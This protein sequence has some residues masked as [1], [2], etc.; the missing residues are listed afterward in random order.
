MTLIIHDTTTRIFPPGP[1]NLWNGLCYWQ[2][3]FCLIIG[4]HAK[5]M[6]C[7]TLCRVSSIIG[8]AERPLQQ[9]V[10]LWAARRP[11]APWTSDLLSQSQVHVIQIRLTDT[12][13]FTAAAV[14]WPEG[15]YCARVC[16]ASR[17]K[18]RWCS[19]I[20]PWQRRIRVVLTIWSLSRA[21]V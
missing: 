2:V 20:R 10:W 8:P 14:C 1:V 9:A 18:R 6:I 13:L 11:P 4:S 21:W 12:A 5:F 3:I 17:L 7:S 19:N 15:A 16:C